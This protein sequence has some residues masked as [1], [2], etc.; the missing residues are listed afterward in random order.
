MDNHERSIKKA[1]IKSTDAIRKKYLT[2]KSDKFNVDSVL[3]K[4]L[5]PITEP[6]KQLVNN[7]ETLNTKI[8]S[9]FRNIKTEPSIN[10][11]PIKFENSINKRKFSEEDRVTDSVFRQYGEE[12][13]T[14]DEGSE[15]SKSEDDS[16]TTLRNNAGISAPVPIASPLYQTF[17]DKLK[18]SSR[19]I[20]TVFGPRIENR[21]VMLGN[22]ILHVTGDIITINNN[23]FEGTRG[24]YQLI[25]LKEPLD[26][27]NNELEQYKQ[28]LILTSAHR[29]NYKK[30]MQINGNKSRKYSNIIREMFKSESKSCGT[31]MRIP[32]MMKLENI[33]ENTNLIY[34][35]NCNELVERLQLIIGSKMAGNTSHNNE[36]IA[37]IDELR[38]A[39][40]IK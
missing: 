29:R 24:L 26:Y 3:E 15:V 36:I 25:F 11:I 30:N 32:K 19:E 7:Q 31:G 12:E 14:D 37:I 22:Y 17:L 1:L 18:H 23:D 10:D 40:I 8:K 16:N 9:E 2:L 5:K 34:W 20:D 38:E 21:L 28:I 27:N 13:E 33:L 4:N 6:L 39:K 35:D